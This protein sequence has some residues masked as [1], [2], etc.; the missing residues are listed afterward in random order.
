MSDEQEPGALQPTLAQ[1]ALPPL[2]V[3]LFAC[4]LTVLAAFSSGHNGFRAA[5]YARA[6]S[7]HYLAI[8]ESG[9]E[10]FPCSRI[11]GPYPPDGWC[12]NAGWLPAYPALI[13]LVAFSG[14]PPMVAG[15]VLSN[16][17]YLLVLAVLW[18][19]FLEARLTRENLGALALAAVFP[20]GIYYQAIFPI[21]L[22]VLLVLLSLHCYMKG[23]YL[24]AGLAGMGAAFTYPTGIVLAAV[25]GG[26]VLLT[27]RPLNARKLGRGAVMCALVAAG[28]GAVLVVHHLSVGHWDALFKTQAK[29]G[30]GLHNP[31]G[32]LVKCLGP[33]AHMAVRHPLF[34]SGVQTATVL[35]LLV[36]AILV[37]RGRL[38]R[39]EAEPIREVFLHPVVALYILAFWGFPLVIG[40]GVSMYRA[41]ALLIPL[42]IPFRRFPRAAQLAL[43]LVLTAVRF[44]TSELFF[45]DVLI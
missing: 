20:G 42:V 18:N 30:H 32:T 40:G 26:C 25:L 1:R 14:V 36:G 23:R 29:Y 45:A 7:Y 33:A 10:M 16:L 13:R 24:L 15:L 17:L 6:D 34:S 19:G 27:E 5:S 37:W 11:G 28:L 2:A 39:K 44:H 41:E 43:F 4:A 38:K 8:A 31:V 9:Y 21:A 35:A 22:L 12:G 3:W